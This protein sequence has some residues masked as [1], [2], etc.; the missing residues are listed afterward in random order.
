MSGQEAAV[1]VYTR[2][3]ACVQCRATDRALSKQGT[4]FNLVHL[5][6]APDVV[7]AA[8]AKGFMEAPIVIDHATGEMWAGF[9]PG[10]IAQLAS[11]WPYDE[12]AA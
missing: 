4:S 2:G 9:N 3:P 10:K 6:D 5:N 1:T 8:K 7:A 11:N 12:E